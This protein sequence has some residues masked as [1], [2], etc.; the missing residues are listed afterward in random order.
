MLSNAVNRRIILL[1]CMLCIPLLSFSDAVY[2]DVAYEAPTVSVA[3]GLLD[4]EVAGCLS[5]ARPGAPLLP[6]QQLFYALPP[7]T[8]ISSVTLKT[9]QLVTQVLPVSGWVRPGAPMGFRDEVSYGDAGPLVDGRDMGLYGQNA[10]YPAASA[11]I[12]SVGQLRKWVIVRLL[13]S[14][15]Q[16]NPVGQTL[17]YVQSAR[18]ALMFSRAPT[19]D[20][21]AALADTMMDREALRL[22]A[23]PEEAQAWYPV[24]RSLDTVSESN[25]YAI[26][27]SDTIYNQSTNLY[28]FI[29]H[30][31]SIG[32]TVLVVT[33]T[34]VNGDA[35][36]TGWNEVTG[37]APDEKADRIRKWLQDNYLGSHIR[38]VLLIGNPVT[39][40]GDVPMKMC[41][42]RYGATSDA[43]YTNSPT[44]SYYADLTGN[45][46]R[47]G[48]GLYGVYGTTNDGGAGGVDFLPEVYVGRF[49]VYGTD[50][51]SLSNII[52]KSIRYEMSVATNWRTSALLPESYSD[53]NGTDGAYLGEHMRT[54]YLEGAGFDTYT[55]YQ[56][57][58]LQAYYDSVFDSD[59]ELLNYAVPNHWRANPY[60]L[61]CWWAHGWSQGAAINGGGT[62]MSSTKCSELDD[63][64]PSLVYMASCTCSDPDVSN[65]L[66]FALL[67]QGAIGV[68]GA[69]RV[70]WYR[71]GTWY[72]NTIYADNAQIGYSFMQQVATNQSAF[73]QALYDCKSTMGEVWGG[74]SWMN[75]FDFN[76]YG[77]PGIRLLTT[78]ATDHDRDRIPDYWE[79]LHGLSTNDPSDSVLDP[80]ADGFGN[81]REYWNGT[82]PTNAD[83]MQSSYSSMTAVGN[84]QGWD[85]AS[86]NMTLVDNYTWEY[87]QTFSSTTNLAFKFTANGNW[88]ANWG[89]TDPSNEEVPLWAMT[90][91]YGSNILVTSTLDG[92]YRFTFNERTLWYALEAAVSNDADRDGM[93]MEWEQQCGLNPY[94]PEDGASDYD[95][96]TVTAVTEYQWGTHPRRADSDFDAL[97]DGVDPAPTV[98]AYA[99][100]TL[101]ASCFGHVSMLN[102]AAGHDSSACRWGA[103]P[104]RTNAGYLSFDIS[105]LPDTARIQVAALLFNA[106]CTNAAGAAPATQLIGLRA[107][108]PSWA[109][110]ASATYARIVA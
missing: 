92:L 59:E 84:F 21:S 44:D 62:L 37:Q 80:D 30:K 25:V 100:T 55:M 90:D 61:V 9:D 104:G 70:S 98:C 76:L 27:T 7:D 87:E 109:Y 16:Y 56:Q 86:N 52:A 107:Q 31:E 3:D 49:P 78:Y 33:E 2:V 75:Q 82:S 108:D 88:T 74:H 36:A 79:V 60:G 1:C 38:Y 10:F 20:L 73:G 32:Y 91:S 65:N 96:D 77:D 22:V 94:D 8:D 58:S 45:W 11:R 106:A 12:E 47:D 68:V 14:P 4:V 95:G 46:D 85:P 54:N 103:M 28:G 5:A 18:Y 89:D 63:R 51:V 105:A 35:G 110:A 99:S 53:T 15:V 102:G 97:S 69:T 101:T 19:R 81:Y 13:V 67:K 40:S 64:T 42:P 29:A 34:K 43:S 57:G 72:P 93:P 83:T 66:G 17:R 39:G 6:A 24:E 26:I 23:N 41:Y 48:N 71:V 50:Y